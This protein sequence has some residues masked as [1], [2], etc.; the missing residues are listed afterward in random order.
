MS[1]FQTHFS[2]TPYRYSKEKLIFNVDTGSDN[3]KSS[4]F[5][6]NGL[7]VQWHDS[8]LGCERSRVRLPDRPLFMPFWEFQFYNITK[9]EKSNQKKEQTIHQASS[10]T[11]QQYKNIFNLIMKDF[12][13][14]I[15]NGTPAS[16][17]TKRLR[18]NGIKFSIAFTPNIKYRNYSYKL[19][20]ER[21]RA[22]KTDTLFMI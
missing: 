21:G 6:K 19:N 9:T 16:L 20:R 2:G 14:C 7:L 22:N 4:H 3:L 17:I 8:R 13:S 5:I 15:Q 11:H 10:Q 1:Q 12:G 18:E